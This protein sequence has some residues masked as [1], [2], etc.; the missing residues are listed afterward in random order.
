MNLEKLRH[1]LNL[2]V[3]VAVLGA[4]FAL[5][6]LLPAPETLKSERRLPQDFPE[7]SARTLLSGSFMDKFEGF[8]ADRFP[9][10]DSF[11][12]I[13]AATVLGITL[14]SD[15]SG[16]YADSA[17]GLGEFW[18]M[19]EAALKQSSEK[20]AKMAERLEGI[21]AYYSVIPDKS[22]YAARYLPGYDHAETVRALGETL[23]KLSYVPLE[24]ALDADCYYRTDLHW[25]QARIGK[26]AARLLSA[27]GAGEPGPLP[28]ESSAGTFLGVYAGRLALPVEPDILAYAEIPGLS[29]KYLNDTTL[30]FEPWPIYY[31]EEVAGID[32]YNVFL[33]GPQPLVVIENALAENGRELY[34]FRDSFGSSLAPL[35]ARAYSKVTVIDLRYIHADMLSDFVS[36]A[37]G[38]DALFIYGAQIFNSPGVLQVL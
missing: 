24:G 8:A 32:P 27:M 20:L 29:A 30:K 16:L 13:R 15:K 38:A 31:P 14:Q 4:F 17:V 25:N 21:N 33:K 36:F 11:R 9:F 2:A 3:F 5:G 6:L 10:R 12:A 23:D 37:P 35:L 28:R 22:M 34:L 19:D 7:L 26:A 18:R 1:I